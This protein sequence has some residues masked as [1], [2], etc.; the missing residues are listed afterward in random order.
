MRT[1]YL[2]EGGTR[3]E[4]P[5]R[6]GTE[7][8][9]VR[10][11]GVDHAYGGVTALRG[12]DL[13]ITQGSIVGIVGANGAGKST[14]GRILH[15]TLR[16]TRGRREADGDLRTALVPEGRA[17]FKTLSL[18][19]NL[20]VAAYAAGI[21]G[22]DLRARLA[23]TAEWLPSRLR[24]R[25]GVPAAGSP[26]VS[27]R[28]L[29]SPGPDGTARPAHRRRTGAWPVPGDGR[30]G[31]RRLGRLAH[32]GMTVVLLEQSAHPRR[33]RRSRGGRPARGCDRGPRRALRPDVPGSRGTGLLRREGR[34]RGGRRAGLSRSCDLR[35][36]PV[37]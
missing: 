12:V 36:G 30:R 2:G 20:E 5:H 29:R 19:E 35:C 26:E 27:S 24:E 4:L 31:V 13:A 32:E 37:R 28:S 6:D 9:V 1:S 15:G 7:R 21:R 16:P 34:R 23:E 18:R 22:A 25:M 14:L 3:G 11:D 17:L 33:V 8:V 10:L